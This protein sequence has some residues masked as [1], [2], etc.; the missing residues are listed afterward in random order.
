LT[1]EEIQAWGGCGDHKPQAEGRSWVDMWMQ[2]Q[3]GGCREGAGLAGLTT[4]CVA[5]HLPRP[6]ASTPT[7]QLQLSGQPPRHRGFSWR[8][9]TLQ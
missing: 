2:M 8:R 9:M 5:P 3:W 1:R 7:G 4:A 6:R